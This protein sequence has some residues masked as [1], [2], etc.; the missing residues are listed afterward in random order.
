MIIWVVMAVHCVLQESMNIPKAKQT[1]IMEG[2]Y[3]KKWQ[4]VVRQVSHV[5]EFAYISHC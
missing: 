2:T 5:T 3:D 4:L 1:E